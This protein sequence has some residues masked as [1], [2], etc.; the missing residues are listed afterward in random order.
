MVNFLKS[1]VL[2]STCLLLISSVNPTDWKKKVDVDLLNSYN[3]S[4]INEFIIQFTETANLSAAKYIHGKDNKAQFVYNTLLETAHSSQKTVIELLSVE[5]LKYKSYFIANAVW[6]KADIHILEQIA[7]RPE[8]KKI[9]ANP[10]TQ[11]VDFFE[12]KSASLNREPQIEWGIKMINAD[13]LWRLGFTGQGIVVGGQDTGYSWEVD[14]LITKYRGI[15]SDGD[16]IHDY[17]WYDAIS[18]I[19][20]LSGDSVVM[21]ANNPCG[22]KS[23]FPCDD[24][25]HGTHT[26]G[27]MVGR[28]SVN[29][30]GIAPDAKWMGCRNME[31][32]NG[33]PSTYLDC[34]QFLFAPTDLNGEN[35]D[36]AMAPH[37]INNSWYCS[38]EEGCNINNWDVLD[39][40]VKALKASG[41][42][43]VV[44][45]GNNGPGCNTVTGPPAIFESAFSVGA[46]KPNDTIANF[47]SRGLV[48][49][50][51]SF[52]MKPN[53]SAPGQNV[54]SVIK[55][56]SFANFNGTSMAGPHVAGMVAIL[57]SARPELI[58]EVETLE[59]IIEQSAVPK[60]T[61]QV[62]DSIMGSQIP[63]PVY[64]YGRVDVLRAY[65]SIISATKNISQVLDCKIFPNPT[66][67][68]VHV[69]IP[70]STDL[71]N[72]EIYDAKGQLMQTRMGMQQ[73]PFEINMS[74]WARGVYY[75]RM[76]NQK[77]S[78]T[79]KIIK[80]D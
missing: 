73:L 49:I 3:H 14:P 13:S 53:V 25:N 65:E 4:D 36:L 8:V 34:F 17:S 6:T 68:T 61:D 18:E 46:T 26:M 42:F 1:F 11:T 62:C 44:S 78:Q 39:D 64:G 27:T 48:S 16:T 71:L 72:Y 47:S 59:N 30:I 75:L 69:E 56:G 38:T 32:G 22:L 74:N 51:S 21:P 5:Q 31:R 79:H 43:V 67:S 55:N 41:I 45:A 76:W 70:F 37:V 7:S 54:R 35:P 23:P 80:L 40:A 19:S 15:T 12:D 29:Y 60:T 66:N 58:G 50:D 24:L 28:D 57:L 52:R 9:T 77:S 2:I 63:N 20:P 10:W 33:K